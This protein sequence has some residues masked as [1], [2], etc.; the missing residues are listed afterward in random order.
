LRNYDSKLYTLVKCKQQKG[1][2][3]VLAQIGNIQAL[4]R[5]SAPELLPKVVE[6]LQEDRKI[7]ILDDVTQVSAWEELMN[8]MDGIYT[9]LF[10]HLFL[11]LPMCSS[12]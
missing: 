9:E 2:K 1:V 7:I 12:S 8:Y 4:A 6:K 3:E 10:G 5:Q 11:S